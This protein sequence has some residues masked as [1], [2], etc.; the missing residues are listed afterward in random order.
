MTIPMNS[1]GNITCPDCEQVYHSGHINC[2]CWQ[3]HPEEPCGRLSTERLA[4]IHIGELEAA[5][6][7]YGRHRPSCEGHPCPCGLSTIFARIEAF[8]ATTEGDAS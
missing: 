2:S 1:I 5:L 6:W 8:R 4:N 7:I 3:S